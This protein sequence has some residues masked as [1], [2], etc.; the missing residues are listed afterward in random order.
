M[1]SCVHINYYV[2]KVHAKTGGNG[3]IRGMVMY[4]AIFKGIMFDC[5]LYQNPQNRYCAEINLR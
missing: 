3:V 5:F 1:N 2:H 4:N